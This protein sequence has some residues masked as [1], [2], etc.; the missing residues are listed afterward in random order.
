M[1]FYILDTDHLSLFERDHLQ[2]TARLQKPKLYPLA[3]TIITAEEK[4]RGRFAS[5]RAAQSE[6][7]LIEAYRWFDFSLASVHQFHLLTYDQHASEIYASMRSLRFRVGT[8]DLRIAAITL[9]VG[10]ILLTRKSRD[11]EQIPNLLH[12]NWTT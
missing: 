7:Q 12:Q 1:S 6:A 11:F 9:A 3:L 5:I 2:L 8:Q 4:F 10:G